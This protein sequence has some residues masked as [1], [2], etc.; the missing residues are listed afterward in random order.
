MKKLLVVALFFMAT[1]GA[2]GQ[3]NRIWS[4]EECVNYA[5]ENNISV[6]RNQLDVESAEIEAKASKS[7]F[8]PNLNAS[9][10]QNL[11]FGQSISPETNLRVPSNFTS[12]N[13]GINSN[14][15]VFNGFR[16]LT[17]YKQAK[18]GIETSKVSLQKMQNDISL[19][20]VNA[21][22]NILFNKENLD[23]AIVQRKISEE[24]VARI[25]SLVDAGSSPVADLY[26]IQATLA[27]DIQN[28]VSMQNN[29][30]LSL[31][32]LAQILQIPSTGFDVEKVDVGSPSIA[33]AAEN[34]SVIY[35]KALQIMPEIKKAQLDVESTDYDL[36][37]A[38]S[39]FYPSLNFNVGISSFYNRRLGE[40]EDPGL[41]DPFG[42]QM[43][44]NVNY[45]IGL[46]M[47]VPI[48][49]RNV[50][51]N[52]VKRATIGQR[53]TELAL[54]EEKQTLYQNIESAYLDAKSAT[55]TFDA[56][57]ISLKSQMEAFKNAEQRFNVGAMT[58][59]DFNQSRNNLVSAQA[60]LIRS[61]YD[62]VFKM[63]LLKFY[64]GEP[65]LE[66]NW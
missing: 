39:G 19:N 32:S 7:N 37:L 52:N 50:N 45:A 27:N 62:Y 29:L 28:E 40:L 24:Q 59:Y 33:M 15:N 49:N 41:F 22:L 43:V 35:E 46:S 5:L 58:S 20:V 12:T 11:S 21:Y 9:A 36:K 16:N 25:K 14:T 53:Q 38:K 56:A 13:A 60:T 64:Y 3:E 31:L 47:S 48:F 6:K 61:K 55:K 4:L 17:E 57:K 65:I 23:V 1:I 51:K 18:L 44:N 34:S 63:K 30:D 54:A 8:L 42:D 66:Q 26:D 10:S 2:K